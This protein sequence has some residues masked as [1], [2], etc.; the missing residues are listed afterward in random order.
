MIAIIV[1]LA[2]IE[3]SRSMFIILD[4]DSWLMSHKVDE[5]EMRFICTALIL[6]GAECFRRTLESEQFD[7]VTHQPV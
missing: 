5:T 7:T 4:Q 1:R 3:Q 6:K 2:D